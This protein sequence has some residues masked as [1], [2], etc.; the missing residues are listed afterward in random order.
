MKLL[1]KN[2][3]LHH[4]EPINLS[5]ATG[6][7]NTLSGSSGSGKSILLRAV[8]DIESHQGSIYLEETEQQQI[9]TKAKRVKS[10][11]SRKQNK[12]EIKQKKKNHHKDLCNV[13]RS[14]PLTVLD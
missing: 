5:L 12:Y 13:K 1:L 6:E 10:K 3:S 7:V 11:R 9:K 8:A 14:K 4:L 2:V